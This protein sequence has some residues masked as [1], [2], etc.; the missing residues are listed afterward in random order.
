MFVINIIIYLTLLSI[1]LKSL[2]IKYLRIFYKL[3]FKSIRDKMAVKE[4]RVELIELFYDLIF[5]YAISRLTSLI[6]EPING[7]IDSN[8]LFVYVITSFVILQAWLYFTNYVNR[9]GEWNWYEY[10]I[11]CINMISVIYMANTIS[12]NWVFMYL[13]FNLSM[14]IMLL[15]VLSLY[16]VHVYREKTLNCAAGNSVTILSVVCLIYI[17]ALIAI[18]LNLSAVVIWIDVIAV[19]V[20]AFL[21]FFLKGNFDRSI[22]SFPHLTER[23]ELLT[24]ITFGEAIVGMAHFFDISHFNLIPIMVFF[25]ILTMFGSYVVQIHNLVNH[26]R[27]ERSLRLMFSHYFIV[28]SIN[29]VTVAL[30]LIHSGEINHWIV[31]GMMIISLIV[32]YVS[33]MANREYYYDNVKLSRKNILS[34]VLVTFIG[35]LVI[36]TFIDSLYGF[37]IGVLIVTCGN[38]AILIDIYQKFLK[39]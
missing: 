18:Y 37:L 26:H 9:Y 15:T 39:D 35:I 21:P 2:S 6:S 20:G 5:V 32:F 3:I 27:E 22:I 12:A 24:I 11:A 7:G 23:F 31:S 17:L 13:P 29:L 34:M 19:L 30:E 33:I 25:I 28:I 38:L 36:L 1:F 4:K 10:L 8:A 14:L 16:M